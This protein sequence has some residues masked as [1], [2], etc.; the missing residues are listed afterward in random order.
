MNIA[1]DSIRYVGLMSTVYM[2]LTFPAS[3]LSVDFSSIH[4]EDLKR[5]IN[6][7]QSIRC[8]QLLF[9]ELNEDLETQ[10]LIPTLSKNSNKKADMNTP[11]IKR[12][13]ERKEN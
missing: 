12:K 13:K 11:R 5:V 10:P 3:T 7:K 2:M 8:E 4:F 6:L 9:A 1:W